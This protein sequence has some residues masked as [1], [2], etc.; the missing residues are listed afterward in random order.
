MAYYVA[1]LKR[2]Y[3]YRVLIEAY[4]YTRRENF[5]HSDFTTYYVSLLEALQGNSA[6]G[7][8]MMG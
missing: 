5:V 2:P 1:R 7:F 6:S 3:D 4:I 8:R